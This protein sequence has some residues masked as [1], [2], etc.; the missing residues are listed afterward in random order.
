MARAKTSPIPGLKIHKIK[1]AKSPDANLTQELDGSWRVQVKFKLP[2]G[3][4]FKRE[5]RRIGS[6]DEAR[7]IRDQFIGAFNLAC[8]GGLPTVAAPESQETQ[9]GITLKKWVE[10][11]SEKHWPRSVPKTARDYT[12]AVTK[13][14]VPKLGNKRLDQLTAAMIQKA[15]YE[16]AESPT[17]VNKSK[18]PKNA[19]QVILSISSVKAIK[20]ALSS[21]LSI[22]VD[23]GHIQTNPALGIKMRWRGISQTRNEDPDDDGHFRLMTQMEIQLLIDKAKDTSIY[24]AVLFMAKCGLRISEALAVRPSDIKNGVLRVRKQLDRLDVDGNG[25]KIT[26]TEPKTKNSKRDIPLPKSVMEYVE[27]HAVD[28]QPFTHNGLGQWIEPR[29]A[30]IHWDNIVTLAELTPKPSPHDLRRNFVS[31]LLNDLNVPPTTVQ[32][33]AGHANI[34]TTLGYY[35]KASSKNLSDA[36]GKIG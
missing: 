18:D 28:D 17:V 2:D 24:G 29:K 11:C 25:T 21:A 19:K 12:Q 9:E 22:A 5:Q 30:Y 6:K 3:E 10:E 16:I 32:S 8:V 23:H 36:M 4:F 14:I 27:K 20:V 26:L 15:L 1:I 31:H 34:S 7:N 33:L 35:S 13:Y